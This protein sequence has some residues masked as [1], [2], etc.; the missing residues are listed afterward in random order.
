MDQK[1]VQVSDHLVRIDFILGTKCRATLRLRSLI[2]TSTIAFKVQT[3]SPHN[4][5]VN[6]PSGLIPPLSQ[7]TFQIILKPQPQIPSSYPR[8]AT[9]RFLIRTIPVGSSESVNPDTITSWTH[10]VKL[11]VAFVGPFLLKHAV[12]NGDCDAVRSMVK[13][14]RTVLSELSVREAELLYRV[15][16][17]LDNSV[18]MVSLL[19]GAGLKVEGTSLE[20]VE[21]CRWAEKGWS[22]LHVAVAFDRTDEVTRLIKMGEHWTLE[23]KDRDGRTPLYLAAS[24]GYERCVKVLAGAGANVDARRN[25]GCTALYRAAMKG[26]RRMVK[27][28]IDLGADP[29][30]VADDRHRSAIDVARDEGYNE[31]V[32]T[33]ERGE[34]VLNAARRGDIVHLESLLERDAS[35]DFRDQYGLTAIHMAA[36]KGYKDVV[37]LLVEFGSDL[38]CTDADGRT[39]LHMAVVGGCKDTVEVLINRGA[40]LNAK[41]NRGA[42]PLQVA[43]T[44]GYDSITQY[45]LDQPIS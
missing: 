34:D 21:E 42:T 32:E 41:C 28:L 36:I 31:I 44:M 13:L 26:N 35:V 22:E 11:K 14:Q 39:P 45:L 1:L 10:D 18:D 15:A 2:S 33:L 38:E 9:D 20:E 30:I 25:D 12:S 43:H 16:N 4:F 27:V 6:P 40:N 24:K 37:M 3:S 29:S 19:L 23:C 7:T 8:S 17:R 5:L